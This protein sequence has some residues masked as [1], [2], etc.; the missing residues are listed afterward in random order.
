ML[1]N[2]STV[3]NIECVKPFVHAVLVCISTMEFK[4]VFVA[5]FA[6]NLFTR[7]HKLASFL[8]VRMCRDSR[9]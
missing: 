1:L 6:R 5:D 3:G 8:Q 2:A 7:L 4:Y 9:R